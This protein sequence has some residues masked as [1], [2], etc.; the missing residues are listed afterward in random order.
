MPLKTLLNTIINENVILYDV[1]MRCFRFNSINSFRMRSLFPNVYNF[2]FSFLVKSV[3][4][5]VISMSVLESSQFLTSSS[6]F[7]N[8]ENT[9]YHLK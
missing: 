2:S 3:D 9:A 7:Y 4:R 5:F 8:G 1:G 6:V